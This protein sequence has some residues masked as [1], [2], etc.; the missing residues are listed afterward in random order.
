MFLCIRESK[1]TCNYNI[2]KTEK[3]LCRGLGDQQRE[4]RK[5]GRRQVRKKGRLLS[6]TSALSLKKTTTKKQKLVGL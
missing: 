6:R 4:E 1:S 3:D 5:V 2:D